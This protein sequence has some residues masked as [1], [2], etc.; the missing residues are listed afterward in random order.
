MS[1][2]YR[3]TFTLSLRIESRE[4]DGLHVPAVVLR[5][6]IVNRLATMSE[7]DLAAAIGGPTRTE[8]LEVQP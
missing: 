2:L 8:E 3:H 7:Q 4:P 6:A 5:A 1:K